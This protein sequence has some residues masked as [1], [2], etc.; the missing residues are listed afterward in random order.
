M[1][2]YANQIAINF[3]F[4]HYALAIMGSRRIAS[5][6]DVA[7]PVNMHA[8]LFIC[9]HARYIYKSDYRCVGVEL[10]ENHYSS[11]PIFSRLCDYICGSRDNWFRLKNNDKLVGLVGLPTTDSVTHFVSSTSTDNSDPRWSLGSTSTKE[12][13]WTEGLIEHVVAV[14]QAW[15]KEPLHIILL[16]N[17]RC[18]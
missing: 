8:Q 11:H 6:L 13:R 9:S 17:Y 4:P 7:V 5:V 15:W 16:C 3:H 1:K 18:G 12:I 14:G 10:F 2:Y